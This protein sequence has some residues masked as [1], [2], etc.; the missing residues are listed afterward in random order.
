[1]VS[2]S[3]H[4]Y[5]GKPAPQKSKSKLKKL[6]APLASVA[7]LIFGGVALITGAQSL[8]PN[9]VST[10]LTDATDIQCANGT[11]DK[12]WAFIETLRQGSLPSDTI[13]KLKSKNVLVGDL[14]SDGNFTESANGTV[15]KKGDKI[16]KANEAYDALQTDVELF[17]ALDHATYSCAAFYYDDAAESVFAD[18]H[19]TRNNYSESSDFNEVIDSAVNTG[20]ININSVAYVRKTRINALGRVE[21]YYEYE[22]TGSNVNSKNSVAADIVEQTRRKNPAATATES[23]LNSADALKVADTASKEQRSSAFFLYFVENIDKMKAGEGNSAKVSE[24]MNFLNEP[25]TNQ[26]VDVNTGN[27]VA[28]TGTPLESPSLYAIL[29]GKSP[30]ASETANY[31]S[32]RILKTVE[33]QVGSYSANSSINSTVASFSNSL[34]GSIG[35]FLNSGSALADTNALS[36]VTATVSDSLVNNSFKD[37]IHGIAGGELLVEGATNVGKRLAI[38]GSGATAGDANA[39]LAYNRENSRIATLNSASDRLDRSPFDITSKNTFLGSIVHNLV[40][41]L[42]T[43]RFDLLNLTL[44]ANAHAD[45]DTSYLSNFGD[46]ETLSTINAV[47]S[48]HCSTIATFDVSTQHDPYSNPE[49]VAFVNNNTYLDASGNRVVKPNSYLAKFILYNNR[50]VTPLGSVDSGILYSLKSQSGILSFFSNIIT[51]V[52]LFRNASAEEKAIATGAAFVNSAN[53]PYWNQYKYAQ[54][55]VSINRAVTALKQHSSDETAYQ[56]LAGFEGSIDPVLAFIEQYDQNL[57]STGGYY[58]Q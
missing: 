46:C 50:R 28:V 24:A 48:T 16:I 17:N 9:A 1:M 22:A 23:A 11:I 21:T 31:S 5:T 3:S 14:D 51:S 52:E 43:G 34:H 56:S 45:S 37:S 18:L 58:A 47:G 12:E 35:R 26:I 44:G 4:F 25:S 15:L 13:A 57:A 30:E 32:D 55:Y 2:T 38:M 27:V 49:F 36:S 20:D 39:V 6:G 40:P 54:R 29:T 8:L 10:L 7:L 33:N 41:F 53:N 19:T 42:A